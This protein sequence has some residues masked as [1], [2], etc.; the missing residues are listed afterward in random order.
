MRWVLSH[1][2]L[3]PEAE[4]EAATSARA[5]SVTSGRLYRS[6]VC[7]PSDAAAAAV[8]GASG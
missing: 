8:T 3:S 2:S 7:V 4:A 5:T 1:C 6:Y